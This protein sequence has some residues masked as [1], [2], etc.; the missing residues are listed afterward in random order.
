MTLWSQESALQPALLANQGPAT[1]VAPP[2][3]EK[4]AW[5]HWLILVAAIMGLVL[6][7]L[8]YWAHIRGDQESFELFEGVS[9]WPT[10][11]LHLL[12]LGLCVYYLAQACE[13]LSKRDQGLNTD[14]A[15]DTPQT[16]YPGRR[17]RDHWSAFCASC[18]AWIADAPEGT[19]VSQLQKEFAER[20]APWRRAWRSTLLA[21]LNLALF[22]GIWWAFDPTVVQTRGAIAYYCHYVTLLVTLIALAGILMFVVDS[23]LL[24]YRFVVAFR[25][26]E[27]RIWPSGLVDKT[28]QKWGAPPTDPS[29]AAEMR[30]AADQWLFI[31][32]IDDVTNV[33]A[34]MIYYP[35]VV[36]L[37]LIVAQNRLFDDW[38][39]NVPLALMA[40]FNA[41]A[42][43]AC[44]AILQ[45]EAKRARGKSLDA[46]DELLRARVGPPED[47][48]REKVARIRTE[49]EDFQTGAFASFSQN[50]IVK[51]ILLPLFGGGGLAA[52]EALLS[53]VAHS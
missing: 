20:G 9:I 40:I 41:A 11:V 46:L 26:Q 38:H 17:L 10:V 3:T 37:V 36:L 18:Q 19:D 39:W 29:A 32:F 21:V 52:L 53:F 7:V 24:S 4:A 6:S 33:V 45:L 43:V 1:Q 8:I 5:R 12:A 42:P 44:A 34:R 16:S 30:Q 27:K 13:D 48:V 51:A 22:L 35:F 50:P 31:R 47:P 23:T 14:F 2:R 28:A 49:I 25:R 15:F